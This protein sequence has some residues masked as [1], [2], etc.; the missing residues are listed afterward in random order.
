MSDAQACMTIIELRAKVA[1]LEAEN[2]ALRDALEFYADSNNK[3]PNDGPWGVSSNDFGRV[4]REA[5]NSTVWK[6]LG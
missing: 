4:A 3:R 2:K 6:A 1:K 5:L